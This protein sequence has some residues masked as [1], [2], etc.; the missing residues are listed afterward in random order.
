MQ[1][2]IWYLIFIRC[3]FLKSFIYIIGGKI[4]LGSSYTTNTLQYN[5][6]SLFKIILNEGTIS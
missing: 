4:M 1:S 6:V 3:N 5:V 2:N